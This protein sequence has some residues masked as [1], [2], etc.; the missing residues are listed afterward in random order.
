MK[1][2]TGSV[3]EN[4][5]K[6]LSI[7]GEL[8]TVSQRGLMQRSG[9]S[10]GMVNLILRRLAK[11][12]YIKVVT[13]NKRKMRYLLT[14]KGLSEK[15][16]R[17]YDYVRRTIRV[18]QQYRDRVERIIDGQMESGARKFAVAGAG[19]LADLV[20][21]ILRSKPEVTFRPLHPAG[22][23]LTSGEVVLDCNQ[24]NGKPVQGISILETVIKS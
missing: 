18:F 9:L 24:L 19:E 2:L 10:L 14:S 1:T 12:G 4:E 17:S 11:T 8:E 3:S 22:T 6:I 23:D 21:I 15:S 20:F 16:N 5:H 13:L 7:I